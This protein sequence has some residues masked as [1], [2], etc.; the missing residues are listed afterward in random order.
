MCR[1]PCRTSSLPPI[2]I[3][4]RYIDR[5]RVAAP[6]RFDCDPRAKSTG[7]HGWDLPRLPQSATRAV[8]MSER[9]VTRGFVGRRDDS[10]EGGLSG[11]ERR[12]RTPP[13]Q[14]L[15]DGFPV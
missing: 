3:P 10:T 14:Y 2:A 7:R 12:R 11:D 9:F 6:F 8:D 1:P 5:A 15:T 4:T 13:G